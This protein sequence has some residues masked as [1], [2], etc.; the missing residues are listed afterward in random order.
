MKFKTFDGKEIPI[1]KFLSTTQKIIRLL[2]SLPDGD[3]IQGAAELSHRA[4]V[5]V[6]VVN[7]HQERPELS[8]YFLSLSTNHNI[9]ASKKTIR[10]LRKQVDHA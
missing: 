2:D 3:L 5:S 10:E 7:H 9:W 6:T 1:G 8:H 4:R